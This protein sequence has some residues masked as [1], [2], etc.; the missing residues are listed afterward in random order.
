MDLDK[1]YQ[2]RF[3]EEDLEA[4]NAVWKVLCRSFFQSMVGEND[5]VLDLGA[6]LGEFINNIR[7]GSK[8]AVEIN[9]EAARR[10]DPGARVV[11]SPSWDLGEVET[12]TVDVVFASNFFEHLPTKKRLMETLEEIHRVLRPGGKILILQPNLACLNGS[13]FDFIDHNLPLTHKSMAEAL[14]LTGFKVEKNIKKFLPFTTR[15]LL[16]QSPWMV[17]LYLKVRPA[18]MILG[19]Q[20]FI[21]ARK[22]SE[23]GL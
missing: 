5:T 13:F 21:V 8:I 15:S 9:A 23:K 11:A 22:T 14:T 2:N 3:P 1:L 10:L 4:K 17:A 12:G 16:P 20:M 7:C 18:W 6:G 19:K